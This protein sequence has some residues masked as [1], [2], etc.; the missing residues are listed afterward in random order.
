MRGDDKD[1]DG[2]SSNNII[3]SICGKEIS[4]ITSLTTTSLC[5]CK[6]VEH[7]EEQ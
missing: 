3:K 2:N 5:V 1:L 6:L 4:D 7:R